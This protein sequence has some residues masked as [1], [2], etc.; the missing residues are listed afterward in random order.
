M[1]RSKLTNSM[2]IN[3]KNLA[4]TALEDFWNKDAK[5]LIF[6]GEWCK[7][8]TN[9]SMNHQTMP[10]LWDD[11][12][13]T[14]HA[15]EKC[16]NIY[17]EIL[18]ILVSYL[19]EIHNLEKNRRYWE[20][21]LGDYII[22]FIQIVYDRYMNIVEFIKKY[23][24]FE[25]IFLSK[26]N[27]ITPLEFQ[28][29]ISNVEKDGYNL[30]LY[31]QI[32]EFLGYEFSRKDYSLKQESSYFGKSKMNSS[33]F[34]KVLKLFSGKNPS[35]SVVSP[36]FANKI[37]SSL[38]LLFEAK[39][40]ICYEDFTSN[41][42]IKLK[43]DTDT[44][45]DFLRLYNGK[46]EFIKLLFYLFEENFPLLFLEGF[47]KMKK[48]AIS[49]VRP[50][51]KIYFSA[52]AFYYNYL[53]KFYLAE[54]MDEICIVNMQHGGNH[55][56]DDL[57]NEQ[58][59]EKII[60]NIYLN[61]G[62]QEDA[63]AHI[64][65]HEKICQKINAKKN[66]YILFVGTTL[67][68]YEYFFYSTYRSS[69]M[70]LVYL[71]KEISFFNSVENIERFLVRHYPKDYGFKILE[72]L[73][74]SH[75]NLKID[76]HS[77]KFHTVL[78]KARLFVCDHM[79]TTY[80]EALAMNF[81]TVIFIDKNYYSFNKPQVLHLLVD[82]K[83]LFYDEIEAANHINRIYENVDSWWLLPKVQKARE[84]FCSIYAKQPENWAKEWVK[85][86]NIILSKYERNKP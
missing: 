83:I 85:T 52:N 64:C 67:P 31:S 76:D 41:F 19:N 2:N 42:S 55:G 6:L 16:W 40:S 13:K 78:K 43:K 28:N 34:L 18:P 60:C 14:K 53:Y 27:Y 56:I 50:K 9:L 81:P 12:K 20:I 10:Y 49:K 35:V 26:D 37:K 25:T 77:R 63:K 74:R 44:R 69:S 54:N 84:C 82:A 86:F 5:E 3:K 30:Q 65:S 51:S 80:L 68:R 48:I 4:T 7:I 24:N 17:D 22:H 29:L 33:I 46:D 21:I 1:R 57:M 39:G 61:W 66:G 15:S 45:K 38:K 62:W 11:S 8:N 36:Y 75:P 70:K 47:E 73:K 58:I 32:L 59:Y 71:Q 79:H 23:P 72:N